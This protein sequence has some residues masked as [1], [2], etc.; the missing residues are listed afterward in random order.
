MTR[1]LPTWLYDNRRQSVVREAR[2][3]RRMSSPRPERLN[4]SLT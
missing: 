3:Q 1:A 4:S 2:T